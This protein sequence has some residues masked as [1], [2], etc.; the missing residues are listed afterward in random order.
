MKGI[1]LDYDAEAGGVLR[2]ADDRRYAFAA[3]EWKG[4]TPPAPGQ[5]ADFEPED[6]TA[7]SLYPLP[8]PAAPDAVE[9]GSWFAD[10]PGLPLALLILF[11]CFLPFLT[12][13]PLSA[14]LFNLVRVAEAAGRYAPHVNLETGLWL[15]HGLYAVPLLA[16]VLVLQ[17]GRGKAGRWLR[18]G[19]GIVALL[20]PPAIA[21][22]A[23]ALFTATPVPAGGGVLRRLPLDRLPFELLAPNIGIGWMALALLGLVLIAVGIWWPSS[24]V[25]RIA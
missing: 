17:E 20:G 18:I 19:T 13:G 25:R 6:G 9:P 2:G 4:E 16:L 10:R 11:A 3:G 8:A 15:F 14:N 1:V 7:R 22:G 24:A 12:L 21:L 5:A 23:R